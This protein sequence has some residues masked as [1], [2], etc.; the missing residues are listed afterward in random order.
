MNNPRTLSEEIEEVR[1]RSM[2]LRRKEQLQTEGAAQKVQ[3]TPVQVRSFDVD[4][5]NC[6]ECGGPVVSFEWPIWLC[7]VCH[8]RRN[9]RQSETGRTLMQKLEIYDVHD[10][11]NEE[12]P[13]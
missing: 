6:P 2:A 3:M 9:D 12:N 7:V 4:K 1:K 8:K 10:H 13:F 5:F 11:S